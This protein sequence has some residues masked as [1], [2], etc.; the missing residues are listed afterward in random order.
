MRAQTGRIYAQIIRDKIWW[1]FTESELSEW[2][3]DQILTV[4]ITDLSPLPQVGDPYP[5]LNFSQR[6]IVLTAA[7]QSHLD[8][9]ARARGYDNIFTA[10]TYADEPAVA[11]FQAEGKIFRAWRSLVWAY[12]AQA[13]ADVT[14]GTRIEPSAAELIAELP[15][16]VL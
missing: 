3:A 16:V 1:I 15:G 8:A 10:C 5:A 7:V 12:C 9:A 2:N 6:I 13:L 11:Q 14:S 4:D